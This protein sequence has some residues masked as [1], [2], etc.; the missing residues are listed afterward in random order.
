MEAKRS[1]VKMNYTYSAENYF[2]LREKQ[3]IKMYHLHKADEEIRTLDPLRQGDALPLSYIRKWS[4]R[5]LFIMDHR[6]PHVKRGRSVYGQH[7][8][9]KTLEV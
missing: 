2:S 5:H 9:R 4:F 3:E 7:I 1:T 8:Y 6:G